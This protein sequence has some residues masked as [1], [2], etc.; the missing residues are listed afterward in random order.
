MLKRVSC[1]A[2]LSLVM[3]NTPVFADGEYV[4]ALKARLQSVTP[5]L[6][7]EKNLPFAAG[8][9]VLSTDQSEDNLQKNDIIFALDDTPV[10]DVKALKTVIARL[11]VGTNTELHLVRDKDEETSRFRVAIT[12]GHR[13]LQPPEAHRTYWRHRYW[14]RHYYSNR[15]I[16]PAGTTFSVVHTYYGTDR[17]VDGPSDDN[18]TYGGDR[19]TLVYGRADVTIP[20]THRPGHIETAWI[21]ND[22][23]NDMTVQS[24]TP[25]ER[26]AFYADITKNPSKTA[27]IFVHGY[28]NSFED[29]AL[30][31][32]QLAYDM[33]FPGI[34][35]FFSWPSKGTLFG[36]VPDE[37]NVS[38]T[39]ADFKTF[40]TDYVA[41]SKA[42]KFYLVCHS[43]GCRLLTQAL[44]ELYAQDPN[45]RGKIVEVFLAAPDIDT[46]DFK[47]NTVQSLIGNVNSITIYQSSKDWAL[48]A[49]LTWHSFQRLGDCANGV[50]ILSGMNTIDATAVDT[51]L[52]GHSYFGDSISVIADMVDVVGGHLDPTERQHLKRK[53]IAGGNYWLFEN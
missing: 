35:A 22:P 30:R 45:L 38:W 2:F 16:Q 36:Y 18:A 15:R 37:G 21:K 47:T 13:V 5:A 9:L 6:M 24:A 40:L 23:D 32:A 44:K 41:N 42:E 50:T 46:G 17:N 26:S 48:K 27:L 52:I 25:L 7:Q 1:L 51:S 14:R 31:T 11:P 53:S 29:A 33:R 39:L 3:I 20:V 12:N 43:M 10:A 28:Y 4:P 19:G 8:V 49:S 34:P